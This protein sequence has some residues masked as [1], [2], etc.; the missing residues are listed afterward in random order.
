MPNC[1]QSS[2]MKYGA[3]NISMHEE[4]D[5]VKKSNRFA[6]EKHLIWNRES[7]C[8]LKNTSTF[9]FEQLICINPF[10]KHIQSKKN[11]THNRFYS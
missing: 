4:K 10:I 1:D 7:N 9:T 2:C 11:K 5:R 8:Y 3:R 6:Q